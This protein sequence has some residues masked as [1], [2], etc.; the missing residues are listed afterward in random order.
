MLTS[1][2]LPGV[3]GT[4]DRIAHVAEEHPRRMKVWQEKH[5]PGEM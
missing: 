5:L 3:A 2:Q 4:S 1:D